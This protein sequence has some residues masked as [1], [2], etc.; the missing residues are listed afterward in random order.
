MRR[1]FTLVWL[2][3]QRNW[4][5][6]L[7]LMGSLLFWAW[8]IRQVTVADV[9]QRLGLR[10]GLLMAA[11]AIGTVVLCIMIGRIRSETRN[12]QYQ[13]LLMSPPSG[14]THILARFTYAAGTAFAYYVAIGF[15]FWWIFALAGLHFDARSLMDI[16]VALPFYGMS[17]VVLPLLAY[18]LLLMVFTSAYRVSGPGWIPGV[19]MVLAAPFFL[20]QLANATARILWTLPAWRILEHVPP[21]VFERFAPDE[22]AMTMT[23]EAFLVEYAG[24]PVEPMLLMLGIT[25]VLLLL[26]GRIWQEVEA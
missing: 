2:E 17:A 19:A 18:T 5:W 11:A 3:H 21:G 14:Y 4:M 25:I 20:Q 23:D 7:P 26:A 16:V 12:G 8:G 22:A 10:A 9:G 15:L 1:F 24:V 13:V 6:S